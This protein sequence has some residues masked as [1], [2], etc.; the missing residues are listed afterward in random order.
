[1][2]KSKPCFDSNSAKS[3]NTLY[4]ASYCFEDFKLCWLLHSMSLASKL[5]DISGLFN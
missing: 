2:I 4:S 3:V 5:P 1:M